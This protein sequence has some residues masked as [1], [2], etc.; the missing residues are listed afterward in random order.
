MKYQFSKSLIIDFKIWN[1]GL[2][3]F[4]F[5]SLVVNHCNNMTGATAYPL[6]SLLPYGKN[7]G[8]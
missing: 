4:N 6:L 8:I 1:Y 2:K 7:Y 3:T 5:T